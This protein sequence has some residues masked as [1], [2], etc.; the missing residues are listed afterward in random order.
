M[1]VVFSRVSHPFSTRKC[2][3]AQ[4][5]SL[6]RFGSFFV[7]KRYSIRVTSNTWA[8]QSVCR[9]KQNFFFL[10]H[11]RERNVI[12]NTRVLC[13][14]S[15]TT[16]I[17]MLRVVARRFARGGGNS[18]SSPAGGGH[19]LVRRLTSFSFFCSPRLSKSSLKRA[20]AQSPIEI[21]IPNHRLLSAA[22]LFLS[23]GHTRARARALMMRR[24]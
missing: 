11:T 20:H 23:I 19:L 1:C 14:Y 2:I 22:L 24:R 3:D 7:R 18:S 15:N 4:N 8:T 16:K 9:G 12:P 17:N 13:S 6:V 21:P 5:Q 10:P